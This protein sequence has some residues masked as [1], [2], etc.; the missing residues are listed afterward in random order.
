MNL[1]EKLV[2]LR[3]EIDTL[4][5]DATGYGYNY[6]SGSQI[7]SKALPIMNDLK[8]LLIPSAT[9]SEVILS[10]FPIMIVSGEMNY[11]WVDAESQETLVIPWT[12]YGQQNDISKAFGSGLTYSERY[13]WLK[14]LSLPTDDDDPD[15]KDT[16]DKP[17]EN[18]PKQTNKSTTQTN[19]DLISEAQA[20]RFYAIAS[21]DKDL[22][23][24]VL[25]P[26][27]LP[28]I[29]K[30]PWKKYKDLVAELEQLKKG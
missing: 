21:G 26:H 3:I 19:S 9:H 8:L 14:M 5:K 4:N 16:R 6:V 29:S 10:E 30:I 2:V 20:K 23:A 1:H 22:I 15:S 24:R 25:Q 27:N 28:D 17:T 12:Y 7:L 18:P 13:F 11:T